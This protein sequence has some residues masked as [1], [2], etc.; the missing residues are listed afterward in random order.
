[1]RRILRGLLWTVGA[2]VVAIATLIGAMSLDHR[3][4]T[5]LPTPTGSLP[6]GRS[7]Q[8]WTEDAADPLAPV[9]GTKRELV[10]WIWYPAASDTTASPDDYLPDDLLAATDRQRGALIGRV[11]TRDLSKVRTHSRRDPELAGQQTAYPVLLMRAGASSGV[12][13]GNRP[14]PCG[15][16]ALQPVSC[17]MAGRP[18]AR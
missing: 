18:A 10:V 7:I 3:A 2:S 8:V 15:R 9:S 16:C 4:E 1:M 17:T 5:S 11:L 12:E 14:T 13:N 6:V